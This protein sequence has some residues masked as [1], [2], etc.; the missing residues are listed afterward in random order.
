[1]CTV[2]SASV[3]TKTD[4]FKEYTCSKLKLRKL[5]KFY[6]LVFMTTG[7]ENGLCVVSAGTSLGC[8]VGKIARLTCI[9]KS[10][11]TEHNV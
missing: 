7:F 1:V 2:K 5:G 11:E 9:W 6:F 10:G 4:S 3:W 8:D